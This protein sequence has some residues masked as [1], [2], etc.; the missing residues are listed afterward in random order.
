MDV[1]K[2]RRVFS[3]AFWLCASNLTLALENADRPLFQALKC[4]D[5][6]L[7]PGWEYNDV[8][9]SADLN[10]AVV[11]WGEDAVWGTDIRVKNAEKYRQMGV[12]LIAA[13][14]WMLT[15]TKEQLTQSEALLNA[16]CQDID[17]N[18]IAPPWLTGELKGVKDYWG[19]TNQPAFREQLRERVRNGMLS[20]ANMLHLDD[21]MGTAAAAEQ[22]GGCF[23][24]SCMAGFRA[25]LENN[26]SNV[27]LK[28]WGVSDISNFNYKTFLIEQGVTSR[29]IY[30]SKVSSLPMRNLFLAF[31][32]ASVAD[33]VL[34]LKTLAEHTLGQPVPLGI[35][36]WNLSPSHLSNAHLADYFSNEMRHYGVESEQPPFN[37]KLADALDKPMFATATGDDWTKI[38]IGN[39]TERVRSWLAMSYAFGHYFMYAFRQWAFNPDTGTNW[40]EPPVS[41]YKPI[42]DFVTMHRDLLDGYRPAANIGVL[43]SNKAQREGDKRLHQLVLTLHQHSVQFRMLIAGD[44]QLQHRLAEADADGLAY[45]CIIPGQSLPKGQQKIV[46][47]WVRQGKAGRC[48]GVEKMKISRIAITENS[49]RKVSSVWGMVR[50]HPERPSVIHILNQ[51][52]DE[53]S[54]APIPHKNLFIN[55]PV[56]LTGSFSSAKIHSPGKKSYVLSPLK[57]EEKSKILPLPILERWTIIQLQ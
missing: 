30:G 19:C 12:K 46:D 24:D 40:Y 52:L 49:G 38:N 4:S 53:K 50:S 41:V 54:G 39:E 55:I 45:V 2:I 18:R 21:H 6:A 37:Y 15:A 57:S 48:E 32:K 44:S 56:D 33:F 3:F 17:G 13:N 42:T 23:C 25:W 14:V 16:S 29:A 43:Y 47:K 27:E 31:Q 9:S 7:M 20:G 34:E 1:I 28:K 51:A 35:N 10:P 22:A 36:A 5:V 11:A 8:R 26:V